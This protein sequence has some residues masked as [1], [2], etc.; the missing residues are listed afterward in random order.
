MARL[1]RL[2]AQ[3]GRL[4]VRNVE[5]VLAASSQRAVV[6]L[7]MLREVVCTAEPLV[8]AGCGALMWPF[9]RVNSIVSFEML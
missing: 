1:G 5:Q 3:R 6:C 9:L 2:R 7:E 8:A 4:G